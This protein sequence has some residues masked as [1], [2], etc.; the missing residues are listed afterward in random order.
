MR[1]SDLRVEH[2]VAPIGIDPA[3]PLFSFLADA[4]GTFTAELVTAVGKTVARRT[5][6]LCEAGGF[7]FDGA[8]LSH[9]TRYCYRVTCGGTVA[10]T[11]F[12]TAVA[13][14]A[15]FITPSETIPFPRLTRRFFLP[16]DAGEV[17]M[18]IT[19]LGL[20][21]AELNGVRVGDRYLTP[22]CNDYDVYLRFDTYDVG[23]LCRR[24]AVNDLCV[25]LGAGWYSG[26]YGIDKPP[27]S[28]GYGAASRSAR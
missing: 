27:E 4:E 1:L 11:R 20:Y 22:G 10:Q 7:R 17:R 25:E 6:S 15:P 13:F 8:V 2:A 3:A 23:A 12:E 16:A 5:V 14:A 28:G 21:R 9:G 19:G 24:G 26:R 18:A